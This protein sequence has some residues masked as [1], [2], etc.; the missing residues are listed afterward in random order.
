MS[1]FQDLTGKVFGR[2]TVEGLWP[3]HIR[4]HW[5]CRC[6]CGSTKRVLADNL[7]AG[8]STSC[9]CRRTEVCTRHGMLD[10]P[11]YTSWHAARGRCHNS[12]N[13]GFRD[14]GGR[15]I[16][17]SDRWD[18]FGLFWRE[19][20]STWFKGSTLDRIDNN[21]NY[22][23]GNVRWATPKEQAHNRRTNA[24]LDTP[25]GVLNITQAAEAY[26]IPRNVITARLNAGWPMEMLFVPP[27]Q[28][29]KR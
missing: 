26:G 16:K 28:R 23:F 29:M 1:A 2:W 11:A 22:E 21:G 13:K 4:R 3:G 25:K 24:M 12:R 17:F 6:E 19:M 18:D 27:A 5:R 15:G 8:V 20:G 10:H 7:R 14:Y 9:G